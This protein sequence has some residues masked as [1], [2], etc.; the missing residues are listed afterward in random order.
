MHGFPRWMLSNTNSQHMQRKSLSPERLNVYVNDNS[1]T[2]NA[3]ELICVAKW[4][5]NEQHMHLKTEQYNASTKGFTTNTT[6]Y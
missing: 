4:N 2:Q 3:S 5:P 1:A 6:L